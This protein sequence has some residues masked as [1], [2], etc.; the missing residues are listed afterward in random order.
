MLIIE[1]YAFINHVDQLAKLEISRISN[2]TEQ[3]MKAIE[4][5]YRTRRKTGQSFTFIAIILISLL[6][7]LVIYLDLFK[8]YLFL[9]SKTKVKDTDLNKKCKIGKV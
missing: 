7:G 1:Y 2:E 3:L 4:L 8:L 5:K 6:F 9:K